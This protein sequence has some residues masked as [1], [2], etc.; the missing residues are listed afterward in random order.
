MSERQ[1]QRYLILVAFGF[2]GCGGLG[3]AVITPCGGATGATCVDGQFCK[4]LSGMCGGA[5]ALGICTPIPDACILI[6]APVCGCDGQTYGSQC[7]AD[8]AGVSMDHTGECTGSCCDL[9]AE[10]GVGGN[11]ICTDG[12]SC[13][14]DGTWL[15]NF[16]DGTS[17]CA[18]S[19]ETC[20]SQC[21]GIA[22]LPCDAGEYCKL[23]TGQCCCDI[24]GECE[25][26]PDAC[27]TDVQLVC[28]CDG[29]TYSNSC[30]AASAGVSVDHQGACDGGG[31]SGGA[32]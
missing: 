18:A 17:L 8:A 32:G 12:A 13:C 6:F 14:S 16:A 31:G 15:C 26:I 11:R 20:T 9:N 25:A 21:G 2:L 7:L 29:V 27:T 3:C 28:G 24:M 1:E 23:E 5:D 19:G 10:P 30:A 22:G 4:Q